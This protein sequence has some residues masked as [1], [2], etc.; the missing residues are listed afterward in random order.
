MVFNIFITVQGKL[1]QERSTAS[2][3]EHASLVSLLPTVCR[4]SQ[5]PQSDLCVLFTMNVPNTNCICVPKPVEYTDICTPSHPLTIFIYLQELAQSRRDVT[6]LTT[7]VEQL[8]REKADLVGE[9]EAHKSSV[10]VWSCDCYHKLHNTGRNIVSI[11]VGKPWITNLRIMWT[12]KIGKV[13]VCDHAGKAS[14]DLIIHTWHYIKVC[15]SKTY[16]IQSW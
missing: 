8:R 11:K 4:T 15:K 2:S 12:A 9:V 5:I 10:R 3:Q 13:K 14:M 7:E 16:M 1:H 6:Q